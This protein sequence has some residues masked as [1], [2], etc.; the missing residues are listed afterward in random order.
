MQD[1]FGGRSQWLRLRIHLWVAGTQFRL[2][3]VEVYGRQES[4][5][6]DIVLIS[7][8]LMFFNPGKI[9]WNLTLLKCRPCLQR[10]VSFAF[11]SLSNLL[12]L[13]R[14]RLDKRRRV[15]K[16]HGP[17]VLGNAVE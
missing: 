2:L 13:L 15:P 5:G 4:F 7:P 16:L 3:R 11:Q 9:E 14:R 6:G 8:E 12:L 1:R 10:L 17:A